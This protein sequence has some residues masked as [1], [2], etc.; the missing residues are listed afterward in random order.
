MQSPPTRG[1]PER[2]LPPRA[3]AVDPADLPG[4]STTETPLGRD[5]AHRVHRHDVAE[6]ELTIG[7]RSTIVAIAMRHRE[8]CARD[9][10]SRRL[11]G[12][13]ERGTVRGNA[14][15]RTGRSVAVRQSLASLSCQGP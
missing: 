6:H 14:A 5:P 2:A 9:G 12:D 3:I 13:C 7:Q 15:S 4:V 11:P 1:E 10:A 8:Q